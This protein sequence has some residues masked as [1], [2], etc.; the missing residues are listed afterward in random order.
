MNPKT[1]KKGCTITVLVYLFACILFYWVGGEQ[2]RFRDSRTDMLTP[3]GVIGEI[4]SDVVVE[5]RLE[6]EGN[7]LTSIR[8]VGATYARENSGI[9]H[10]EIC[11]LDGNILSIKEVDVSGLQDNAEFSLEFSDPVPVEE[12]SVLLRITAPEAT[13]DNSVTL[14]YG[15]TIAASRYEL[16][17]AL[18]DEDKLVLNGQPQEYVLCTQLL[19]RQALWFGSF[20]WYFVAGTT[21]FLIGVCLYL[22]QRNKAGKSSVLLKAFIAFSR[23]RYLMKQLVTRDFKT[24][25]KR[26]VLGVVWSF[27]NPLLTML[28]QYVVFSTLFKSDIPN[29]ALYLLIGIVCFNFFSEATSMCL[30]SIVGNASLITKVYMPKY[31][32]PVTRVLSS[33]INFLLALVP[34]FVVM[35]ITWAPFRPVIIL[36]PLGLVCLFF[37]ALGIGMLLSSAMV[38]FRD[39]Q[40]LWGVISMLWM[41]ATPIFYPES[42]IAEKYMTLYKMNPLYH[43]VRF[44]RTILIDGVSPEPKAY[45]LMLLAS[46]IPLLI[47]LL[48]FK[49][50]QDKFVLNL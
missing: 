21:L 13:M 42:I 16:E 24:K 44:L 46:I 45:G 32:Y 3:S 47:G 9:L 1:L 27:L 19:S 35:L 49:K 34:L 28:V 11:S 43:V 10:F 22:I 23:Y 41:Y 6:V 2:L 12:G 20:Y 18:S 50:T 15:N 26:S 48:V 37:I 25:Y 40:F 38:F 29:F 14:Y 36:L 39:T 31:I 33:T 4:T 17:V 30:M 8:M 7:L 5:Q